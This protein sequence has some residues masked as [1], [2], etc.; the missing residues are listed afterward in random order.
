MDKKSLVKDLQRK[1]GVALLMVL[2]I[3]SVL[4]LLGVA[5]L[6]YVG[7]QIV[8]GGTIRRAGFGLDRPRYRLHIRCSPSGLHGLPGRASHLSAQKPFVVVVVGQGM[9]THKRRSECM[10]THAGS[11]PL[12][13]ADS[14]WFW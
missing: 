3:M 4:L 10:A 5:G 12:A 7:P 1:D 8:Q 11:R 9:P 6:L 14:W 13:R 2:G